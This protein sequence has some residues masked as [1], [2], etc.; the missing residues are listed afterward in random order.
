MRSIH[1]SIDTPS[2]GDGRATGNAVVALLDEL[3]SHTIR[4]RDVY[5]NARWQTADIRFH[6]LRL[7]FEG[8]YREQLR[9]V[10]ILIDRIRVLGGGCHVFAG[11]FLQGT[12]LSYARRGKASPIRLLRDLLDAHESVLSAAGSST[13]GDAQ[14]GSVLLRGDPAVGQVVLANDQQ[15]RSVSEQLI[16]R[17]DAGGV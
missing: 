1:P 17:N 8:H 6:H 3:L 10:D 4:L 16:A 2:I 15:S 13:R 11:C 14:D 7:I 9:L 12:R 5:K